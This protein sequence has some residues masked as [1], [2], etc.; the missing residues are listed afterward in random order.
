MKLF[1]KEEELDKF[2]KSV[3]DDEFPENYIRHHHGTFLC[4]LA[5]EYFKLTCNGRRNF[6][7]GDD[8]LEIIKNIRYDWIA[9]KRLLN[10]IET[11]WSEKVSILKEVDWFSGESIE[12]KFQVE[13]WTA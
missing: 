3:D 1:V 4:P 9:N 10:K 13:K 2:L 8:R 12:K 6:L 11:H 7:I 5:N